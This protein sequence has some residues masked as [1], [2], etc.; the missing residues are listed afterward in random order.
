MPRAVDMTNLEFMP[1]A[2]AVILKQPL[3]QARAEAER[4]IQAK[5]ERK[6]KAAP[7]DELAEP[8]LDAGQVHLPPPKKSFLPEL[9]L[10]PRN[11]SDMERMRMRLTRPC[12]RRNTPHLSSS[13]ACSGVPG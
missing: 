6:T 4:V 2:K 5:E 7:V 1:L 13:L 12:G 3:K 9:L 10:T 11:S 8:A